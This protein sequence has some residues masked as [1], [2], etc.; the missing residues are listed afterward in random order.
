MTSLGQRIPIKTRRE[1]ALMREA[2]RHVAEILA[3]LSELVQPGITTK[4]LDRFAEKKL[5][6]R[7]LESSFK[8]YD[9]YGLPPYP[10][11]LCV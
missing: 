6:E 1:I 8:G 3:E 5:E 4:E 10:G 11:V 2:G 9:P 7:G